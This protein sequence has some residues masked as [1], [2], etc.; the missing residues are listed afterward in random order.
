MIIIY[1]Y[2]NRPH[3]RYRLWESALKYQQG[4]DILTSINGKSHKEFSSKCIFWF[5]KTQGKYQVFFVKNKRKLMEELFYV[6]STV[7]ECSK[8]FFKKVY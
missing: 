4:K 5:S 6:S 2:K 7:S 8:I 3:S 1:C